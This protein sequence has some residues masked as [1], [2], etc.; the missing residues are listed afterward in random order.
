MTSFIQWNCRGLRNN[1]EELKKLIADNNSIA[2]CL[3]ETFLKTN[4]NPI[5]RGYTGYH[6]VVD[7]ERASG[8]SSIFIKNSIPQKQVPLNTQLQAIAVS[9]TLHK[10]IT[11]CSLYLPPTVT[12]NINDLHNLLSQLPSPVLLM[13]DFNAQSTLWG[14]TATNQRGHTIEDFLSKQDLC[15]LN[16]KS[17]TYLH[18][19]YGTYTSIDLSLSSP[20]LLLDLAW[21]VGVDDTCGSDHFP[22]LVHLNPPLPPE[23][24]PRWRLH[25]ADWC[26]FG[27][28]CGEALHRDEMQGQDTSI[29][30]FTEKLLSIATQTIPKSSGKSKHIPK[31]WFSQECQEAVTERKRALTKFK[32]QPTNLN[33]ALFRAARAKARRVI[34]E[35]KKKSW[36]SYISKLNSKTSIKKTWDMVRKISGKTTTTTSTYLVKPD[37]EEVRQ[38]KEIA[39]TIA[40]NITKN[41]SSSNYSEPFQK[42]QKKEEKKKLDFRSNNNE[43]YNAPFTLDEL[44]NSLKNSKDTAMGPDDIHYQLLKHLPTESLLLLLDLFN[45]IWNKGEF[46]ESWREAIVIPLQKPGKDP[47]DPSSYRPIALTSCLCKTMERMINA[48]LVWYLESHNILTKHQ[49]GFRK[50]RSTTDQLVRLEAYIRDGFLMGE[51]VVSVFFDLEKA[52]DT[53]WKYGIMKDLHDSGLRGN[54]PN[55]IKNFLDDRSFKVRI[56]STLS[57]SH[58]QEMGV[59]QGSILSVTLFNLKINSIVNILSP[60]IEKSLY[61]DDFLISFRSKNMNCIERQ[62]QL[63]L[64]EIQNWA[65]ENGFKFST[66]KTVCVHFCHRRG[67]HADPDLKLNNRNIPVV[68][69]TKFL[70]VIF[71]RKLNFKAHIDHLRN[72]C[73]KALNLLKVVAKLDWGADRQVLLR[74]YRSLIRS[75]LDYGSIIYGS[76]RKSYLK[77]LD[78]VQNQG[79]RIC[80]GAFKTSPID[81]LHV[82]ANETP[83]HLRR[84]KLALQYALKIKSTPKNPVYETIF[85][86]NYE[87]LYQNKPNTI[88]SFG[89]RIKEDLSKICE[90]TNIIASSKLPETSPWT[91]P[92]INI[93]LTLTENKKDPSD[94]PNLINKF[95]QLKHKYK[96][97]K[98]IYTDGSKDANKVGAGV[99][100]GDVSHK[101]GLHQYSTIL[102]AELTALKTALGLIANFAHNQFIIFSD[103]LSA[104]EAIKNRKFDNPLINDIFEQLCNLLSQEKHVVLAWVP[105]HIGIPGN[106]RA[107]KVAKEALKEPVSEA[108]IPY[109]DL[110][111]Q[112][113]KHIKKSWQDQWDECPRN[114]LHAIQ[115]ILGEWRHSCREQRREEVVLTRARIGHTHLTHSFYLKGEPPPECIACSCDYTVKHILVECDDFSEIRRRY[116]NVRDMKQLFEDISPTIILNYI[117]EIGLFHRF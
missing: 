37:G 115:P 77:R 107:D 27:S 40:D 71:D 64:N 55:F 66:S 98:T 83:M 61:V 60:T 52:Y 14:N 31:P 58:K 97:H 105:S 33:L 91:I 117:R 42:H 99:V 36:K 47:T 59:P 103:S 12:I 57:D 63:S 68:E 93:D 7:G 100:M 56:G 82:E 81:S 88:P 8:G 90:D 96:N 114:K 50:A 76:A 110:R 92:Q 41:S 78:T 24:Q 84:T 116:Y 6:K 43:D 54:M 11:L 102:T 44:Q 69:Q 3:Q 10:T 101:V 20:T 113:H 65:N 2:A 80:L 19:G 32:M 30:A 16:D 79:L 35:N 106:E 74:L 46:P 111:S 94:A 26:T 1:F 109:T 15:L 89:I 17:H 51:H 13:G 67:L 86:P 73:I 23:R 62:L 4:D 95:R 104:L 108:R 38:T 28:L 5:I 29:E 45:D 21:K 49:S 85:D 72:K 39:N 25:K 34:K 22:I 70:G 112:I 48:R 18:P 9:I 75:K 53:T 87:N